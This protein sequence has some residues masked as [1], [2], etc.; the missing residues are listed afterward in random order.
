MEI[1]QVFYSELRSH[2]EGYG[3][4]KIGARARVEEGETPEEAYMKVREWVE[5][6]FTARANLCETANELENEIYA[7]RRDKD[8]L[9]AQLQ[10][11]RVKWGKAKGFLEKHGLTVPD[12]I[13]F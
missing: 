6:Q 9:E 12:E 8:L 3:N 13:P 11:A 2:K 4:E 7:L 5:A 1:T 10:G